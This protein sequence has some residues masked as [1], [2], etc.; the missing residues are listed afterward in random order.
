M[1][2]VTPLLP[3]DPRRV[4]RYRLTGRVD[5]FAG[6]D[7]FLAQRVDGLA[8]L[9]AFPGAADDAAATDRFVAEARA[10]RNIPPYCVARI[11]DAG[12]EANRPYL[13]TEFVD[14]PTL[15]EVVRTW[16]PLPPAVLRPLA[17]GCATGIASIH[18]AG[19]VHGGFAPDR[20]VLGR[21]GPRVVHFSTT[22]PYGTATPAADILAWA[23]VVTFAATGRPPASE[24]D[25]DALPDDLRPAV[26]DCFSPEPLARPQARALLTGLLAGADLS[27]GLL[28]AGARHSQGAASRAPAPVTPAPGD[29]RP[30]RRGRAGPVLWVTAFAACVVAIAAA[31]FFIAGRHPANAPAP[32]PGRSLPRA[33]LPIPRQVSGTWSGTIHQTNPSLS[34][35]VR[36]ALPG[37]RRHG[38]LAY[39]QLGCTGQL[40]LAATTHSV[41]TFRLAITS[42]RS[43]CVGGVVRLA[44][45]GNR[46]TF[47]FLRPG[48][49][50]P[51]GTLTR[52]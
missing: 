46:M 29:Q 5:D 8:V 50:N 17:A 25:L 2:T 34:V 7:V 6:A 32:Q 16:G 33:D 40:A 43:N 3:G 19:L 38:T 21:D 42:G 28:A 31:V 15:A 39:P 27:G 30:A 22:P 9:A 48:G 24:A 37:G 23:R 1:P 41:L 49:G 26:A 11:L 47:T 20:V 45:H 4:G 52:S 18:R 14:G 12:V 44:P 36:L 35:S 51:A 13:I 10:A